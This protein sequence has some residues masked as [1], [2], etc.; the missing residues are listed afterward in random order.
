VRFKYLV[1]SSLEQEGSMKPRESSNV[2]R[3]QLGFVSEVMSTF[4]FLSTEFGFICVKVEPSFIR[5]E[6]TSIFINIY[7]GRTSSELGVE[8][9]KLANI[10]GIQ[11]NWY[12]IGEVMDLMG[13]RE[14]LGYTF[15]QASTQE[16]V[17]KL[18]PKLAEYVREYA[19]PI[20]EGNTQIFEKLEV[21]RSRKS[22]EY[23]KEMHLSRTREEAE[24]T[25][26]K[27]DY[28]KLVEL[29]NSMKEDLTLVEFKKLEYAQKHLQAS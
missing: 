16:R 12:T 10:P 4:K 13:I 9:G 22:D 23:I 11:E 25:W 15:F 28:A 3:N 19:K 17:R 1:D 24:K 20:I 2:D 27:K 26:R 21:L 7:H 5:Y 6:S 14:K 8:I 29:Y 18:V